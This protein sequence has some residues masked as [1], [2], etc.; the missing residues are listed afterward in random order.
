MEESTQPFHVNFANSQFCGLVFAGGRLQ[1]E[2][3]FMIKPELFVGVLF[4]TT[5]KSNESIIV[6]GA[7]QFSKYTGYA[8]SFRFNGKFESKKTTPAT[9]ISIDSSH[10]AWSG[11]RN[12][13]GNV[14][15]P[16]PTSESEKETINPTILRD[17]YKAYIGFS[18]AKQSSIATG[19]KILKRTQNTIEQQKTHI[20][21]T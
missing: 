13:Y 14:N 2:I 11:F 18:V 15:D 6:S 16:D 9:I 8:A 10:F 1:E 5:M 12:A 17:L 7:R 19:S 21:N 20:T 3:L 4:S